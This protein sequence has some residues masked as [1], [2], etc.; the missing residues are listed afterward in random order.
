MNASQVTQAALSSAIPIIIGVTGHQDLRAED[1]PELERQVQKIFEKLRAQYTDT[2]LL[3][4]SPLAEG[5]DRLVAR[6]A[7]QQGAQLVVPLPLPRSEYERDFHTPES[8]AEFHELLQQAQYF[9]LPLMADNT[10]ENIRD[11]GPCRDKQYAQVSAYIV[12]HSQI[13]FALWDG[14]D[15]GLE[16]GTAQIVR[17]KLEGIP[18][19]YAPPRNPLDVVDAGPVYHI[20]TPRVKNPLP[21]GEPFSLDIKFPGSDA[22]AEFQRDD[23]AQILGRMNTFNRDVRCL[24]SRL[25]EQIKKNKEYLIPETQAARLPETARTIFEQY[26]VADTL[27]IHFQGWRRRMLI[28]LFAIAMLAVI[29][30]EVYAHL[31]NNPWVLVLY[32]VALGSAFLL[33][34]WAM[35]QD[36]QNKHLDYRALAEGLRV[37]LFWHL[38]GLLDEAADHYLR[39]QRT[40]LEWIRNAIRAWSVLAAPT[41]TVAQDWGWLLKEVVLEHWA[42]HQHKYFNSATDRDHK[43]LARHEDTVNG[44]FV[45]GLL[46]AI[47]VVFL[48]STFHDSSAYSYWHH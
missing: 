6:I 18:E 36:Y 9:E 5:A 22:E 19:P 11:C 44:F 17:F 32:P 1:I 48:H 24:S 7:L 20:L 27:A 43:K 47:A 4:L 25:G 29:S 10:A 26:A 39:K 14:V 28:T 34:R 37:Q 40:E 35:R 33:Y 8:R 16:G 42:E 46:L 21:A 15:T 13:L 23:Y 41:C 38:S 31:L 12:R 3:A 30:F 45:F 2:T